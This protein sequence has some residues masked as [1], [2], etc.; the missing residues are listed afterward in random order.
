MTNLIA[1]RVS[2]FGISYKPHNARNRSSWPLYSLPVCPCNPLLLLY[3]FLLVFPQQYT[4]LFLSTSNLSWYFHILEQKT[5]NAVYLQEGAEK[6][7]S[8]IDLL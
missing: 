3:H 4:L 2:I 1:K 6:T 8:T 7:R 5:T